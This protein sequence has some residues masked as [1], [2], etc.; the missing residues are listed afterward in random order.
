MLTSNGLSKAVVTVA[1]MTMR[2]SPFSAKGASGLDH[3][4]APELYERSGSVP[5]GAGDIWA[6]G[7]LLGTLAACS[8]PFTDLSH[9]KKS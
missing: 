5:S 8:K 7:L 9:Q 6:A 3:C 4:S 1:D 2:Q